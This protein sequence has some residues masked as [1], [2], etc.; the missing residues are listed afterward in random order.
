MPEDLRARAL[1]LLARREHSRAELKQKLASG[2]ASEEQLDQ[3]LDTLQNQHLLSDQRY[4]VQR[5]AARANRYGNARLKHELRAS[6][7]A[8]DALTTALADSG[9]EATRCREVWHK[10]FGTRPE[11]R[12]EDARQRRFLQMRGFSPDSIRQI[13]H[14]EEE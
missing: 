4:A 2:A 7:V 6:G 8:E 11:T 1:R 5:V 9:N 13:L 10:K 3:L 14:G 12:A